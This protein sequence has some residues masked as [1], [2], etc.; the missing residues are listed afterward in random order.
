MKR[1]KYILL[2]SLLFVYV[3]IMAIMF[4]PKNHFMPLSEKI[5]IVLI[6]YAIIIVLYFVL[7]K[8]EKYREK[9]K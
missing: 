2:P 7:K 4:L 1:K 3:T 5:I 6:S 8:K 9:D